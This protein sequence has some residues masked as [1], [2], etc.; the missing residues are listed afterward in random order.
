MES[1][2]PTY[3]S[4]SSDAGD[5]SLVRVVRDDGSLDPATDPKLSDELLLALHRAMVRVRLVDERLIALKRQGAISA[6]ASSFGEEGAILG[7]AAALRE[8]DAVFQ[9]DRDFGVALWRGVSVASYVHHLFGNAGDGAKGHPEPDHYVNRPAKLA[10]FGYGNA[11]HLTHAVGFAWGAK[12]KRDDTLALAFFSARDA[13]AGEFHNALNF[14]GVFKP[15][16]I[17]FCRNISDDEKISERGVAY[18]LHS[19]ACD[20]SDALAVFKVT[21]DAAARAASGLGPTL[22]DARIAAASD[23]IARLRRHLETRS[24]W[25]EKKQTELVAGVE[26]EWASA[27][28]EAENKALPG[29]ASMFEDVYARAPWSL[30]EQ[31]EERLTCK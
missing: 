21:R 29:I 22:I 31:R 10:S 14:A 30:D 24:L 11:A 1:V 13:G 3:P 12:V 4:S 5:E 19:V 25:T 27:L 15:K 26:A 18:G 7:A 17:L 16:V 28:S 9:G 8:K 23:P 2:N 20:G 6:H